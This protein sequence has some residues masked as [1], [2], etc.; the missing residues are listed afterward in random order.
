V[1]LLAQAV[2]RSV[3]TGSPVERCVRERFSAARLDWSEPAL[4]PGPAP[5]W[6]SW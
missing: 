1:E 3:V 4:E 2:L 6:L 5:A